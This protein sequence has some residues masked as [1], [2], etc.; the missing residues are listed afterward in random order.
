ML[1]AVVASFIFLF[2][3]DHALRATWATNHCC[4]VIQDEEDAVMTRVLLDDEDQD[5]E[6]VEDD[7]ADERE[8]REANR[9]SRQLQVRRLDPWL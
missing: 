6:A 3:V 9:C 7:G 5:E 4:W 8:H 2:A 1:F